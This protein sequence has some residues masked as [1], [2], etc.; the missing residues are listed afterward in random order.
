MCTCGRRERKWNV[1]GNERQA[2][3]DGEG[4]L[5]RRGEE[6]AEKNWRKGRRGGDRN[7]REEVNEC[8]RTTSI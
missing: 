1:K 2:E 4:E 7:E 6:R 3:D 8:V 5:K